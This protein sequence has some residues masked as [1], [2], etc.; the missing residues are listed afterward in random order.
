M[1]VEASPA[2]A[3]RFEVV[4]DGGPVQDLGTFT[5]CDG[6]GVEYEMLEWPE[7]GENAYVHKLPARMKYGT[8]KLS[9]PIDA[10]SAKVAAWFSGMKNEVTRSTAVIKVYDGN[11]ANNTPIVEWTLE[12]VYPVRWTGPSL[13]SDGNQVAKETLELAHHGFMT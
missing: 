2:L 7:G 6:I 12:G 3:L 4:L 8:V 5:S 11:Y 1:A 9:R 10:N 13:T